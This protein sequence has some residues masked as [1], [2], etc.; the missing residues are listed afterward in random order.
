VLSKCLINYSQF[1]KQNT[2]DILNS[3]TII[4]KQLKHIFQ[5]ADP[6][7]LPETPQILALSGA[8]LQRWLKSYFPMIDIEIL[9]LN[10]FNKRCKNIFQPADLTILPETPQINENNKIH[11]YKNFFLFRFER[12]QLLLLLML[13]II[14]IT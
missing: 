11:V 9:A 5:P 3:Q 10:I 6:I 4:V 2:K 8:H 1:K 12:D 13:L 14:K 7:I